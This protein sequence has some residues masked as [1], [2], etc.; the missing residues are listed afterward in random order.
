MRYFDLA[1]DYDGTL[2]R[3][4][5]VSEET[6]EALKQVKESGRKLILVTGRELDDLRNNFPRLDLFY[7]VVAENGAL[8]FQPGNGDERAL[9]EEPSPHFIKILKER[10][11]KPLC[12]GRVIFSTWE[13]HETTVLETIRD[14]GLELQVIFNKGA[15]MVLPTG[16][17]KAS[18]L[19]AALHELKL[20]P[21]NTVGIAMPKMTTP[22]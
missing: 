11:V 13:P 8:V 5:V 7:F 12:V 6:T 10:E 9:G 19:T 14:F 20:S 18:G 3:H 16:I 4:G 15:V 1:C 22:S 21:R 17:N 2:A